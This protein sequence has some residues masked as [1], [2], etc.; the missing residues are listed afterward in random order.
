MSDELDKLLDEGK[1]TPA[2]S[3]DDKS[4]KTN[5]ET[6]EA[7]A[8]AKEES[9]LANLKKAIE[10]ANDT[11]RK[12]RDEAKKAKN[13][14]TGDDEELPQIDFNDPSSK[15]WDKH[16]KQ[17]VDPLAA[18]L[19]K[20]KD[21]IRTSALSRFLADKPDLAKSPDK[22]KKVMETYDR[23]KTASERTEQ[24]VLVDL[25]RA[26]AAEY[27]DEILSGSFSERLDRARGDAISSDIAVS[28]GS[29]SYTSER[30]AK[31]H[32][33]RADE[34]IL[35]KWGMSPEEWTKLKEKQ[36]KEVK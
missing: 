18:E 9:R 12:T 16:F 27:H 22:L 1:S 10:E 23:I 28:R 25:S 15:A 36:D 19:E 24:G 29:T 30:E 17:Q 6:E 26:Y 13:A 2:P 31:P 34:A 14:L 21:E 8:I 35:A 20:A 5:A 32:L 4:E 33:N 7:V 11:L 3:S